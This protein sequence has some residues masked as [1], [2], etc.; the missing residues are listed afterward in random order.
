M[1]DQGCA[2]LYDCRHKS[3]GAARTAAYR[4]HAHSVCD[5]KAPM[6]LQYT[7]CGCLC[8]GTRQQERHHKSSLPKPGIDVAKPG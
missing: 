3:V 7:A 6:Q 2:W 8:R 5:T 4:L 1:A